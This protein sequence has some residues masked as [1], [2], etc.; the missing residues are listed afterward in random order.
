M[1]FVPLGI[2]VV[3]GVIAVVLPS[4]VSKMA[5]GALAASL[6]TGIR[7]VRAAESGELSGWF[8]AVS[9]AAAASAFALV[10]FVSA[11]F[12]RAKTLKG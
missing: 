3:L 10:W 4:R 5:S 2:G 12:R 8:V 1:L 7:A 11:S 9:V 6:V